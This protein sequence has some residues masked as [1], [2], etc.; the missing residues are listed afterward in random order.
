MSQSTTQESFQLPPEKDAWKAMFALSLGFFVSLL[1]QSMVA[2]ALS[3]IQRELGAS[4]NQVMWVSAIYLLAVVVPL[5]LTGRLGDVFG[6]RRMFRIGMAIFGLAAVAC[7]LAPTIE[8]LIL[9]RAVQGIGA[10]MEIPQSMAVINR[11]FDRTRRGRA[12]GV[13]GIIGSVATLAGPI[14]GGAVVGMFGWHAVFWVH[15]PFAF[16]AVI[17]AGLWVPQLPTTAR[18]I[19]YL[20]VVV[21]LLAVGAVVFAIQQGPEVGWTWWIWAL[22]A[23]GI[24]AGVVFVRLQARAAARGVEAMVPLRLFK[25]RNYSAGSAAIVTMGFMAASLMLP[26]MLWLQTVQ[27]M[28]AGTVGL[29]VAPMAIVSFVL[30]PVAGILADK[31]DP[32]V[33]AGAGFGTLL[34]AFVLAWTV[35]SAG[36]AGWWLALPMAVIGVGQSFVWSSNAATT[37]RDV[38]PTLMGAASGV[39]NTSRQVGSVIGVAAVSAAMQ[40]G[41]GAGGI[42]N[43][44]L[45]IVV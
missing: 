17:L 21:S 43:S 11:V 15:V 36:A 25:D 40:T 45:V 16:A 12:L 29:V 19:D 6:Q 3:D 27:G 24:V 20:S 30:S 35:M 9:A 10:A 32:R 37:M 8:I 2:V 38:S 13:W 5:L 14:V 18:S 34:V 42:A 1:D 41:A 23:V 7:A 31:L 28:D 26:V 22:L 44:L 39:Y 33:M 4:L